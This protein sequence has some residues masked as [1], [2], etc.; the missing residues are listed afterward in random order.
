M[1]ETIKSHFWRQKQKRISVGVCSKQYAKII[2]F[3]STY[4]PVIN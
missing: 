4:F 3:S 2:F 1:A